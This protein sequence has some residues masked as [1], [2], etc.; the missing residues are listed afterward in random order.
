MFKT[1]LPFKLVSFLLLFGILVSCNE[2]TV[3]PMGE[4][5]IAGTVITAETGEPIPAASITTTP[6]TTAIVTD[7]AGKF[8]LDGIPGGD[9][10]VSAKKNGYKTEAV[11][12]AVM[13]GKQKQ[14]TIV[15]GRSKDTNSVP[16]LPA[17]PSPAV[18]AT[19]QPTTVTLKWQGT[20][21]DKDPLTYDVFLYEP[22]ATQKKKLAEGLTDT[23]FVATDL[24]Y[25]TLYLWQVV[26][27]DEIGGLTNGP[28][29]SFS[30]LPLPD[31]RYLFARAVDGNYDIYSST[32]TEAGIFKLTSSFA[33]EWWP[34][35]SPRRDKI[36]YSSNVT[37]DPQ[38]WIMSR[39]GAD[40]RQI[41]TVPVAGYH[42]LGIGFAWSPDG[43]YLV[44]A[45]YDNLYRIDSDGANLRLLAKAPANRHFRMIDWSAQ[46]NR[47][48][49][50]TIGSNINDSEIYTMNADGSDMKL[51]VNNLP[52][53][54]ESPSYSIDGNSIV[55]TR[56]IDGFE[57]KEG[58]QLN[59]HIFVQKLDGSGV[60]DISA[61]KP[62][63]TNDLY[64]RFSPDG[65]KIIFVNTS[66]DGISQM[67]I[68]MVDALDGKNRVK[69]FSNA[70]MPEW[71]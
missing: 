32:G 70:S 22:G 60:I 2:D 58:R 31:T 43:G 5:S 12:V 30:T 14:I 67:D 66:N 35:I 69:L 15:L 17:K 51:V 71:K 3:E 39:N 65:S 24:K 18:D 54:I 16:N 56:D 41:T 20:D 25:G 6:A 28:V 36:A 42:N 29:W 33:R 34:V 53:R 68:W 8:L 9:Y 49:V 13:D 40:K 46:T 19:N 61:N 64:P 44:Y 10:N 48:V 21:P 38:I 37:L 52:G 26:A 23:S 50:Q 55:Y 11:S 27:T 57:S 1:A 63:G 7:A 62:A 47:I 4:G 59:A 45:N